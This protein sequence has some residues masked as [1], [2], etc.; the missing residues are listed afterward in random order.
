MITGVSGTV[1]D[2]VERY[3]KGELQPASGASVPGHSGTAG[4]GSV[5]APTPGMGTSVG[6]G[7]GR[8]A[9]RGTGRG[10]MGATFQGTSYGTPPPQG[11]P[12]PMTESSELESLKSQA[13]AMSKQL[14]QVTKHIR[15]LEKKKS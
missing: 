5:A 4:M 12:S 3:K 9:G 2:G 14:D 7:G 11:T 1:R 13:E 10:M 15:Q 8:G 6:M